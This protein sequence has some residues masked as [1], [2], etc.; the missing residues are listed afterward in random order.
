MIRDELI[1]VFL[2][3][4]SDKVYEGRNR[5]RIVLGTDRKDSHNSG[6]GDGG[7]GDR[8][9]GTIDIVAGYVDSNPDYLNDKSRIYI[10]A[11]TNPDE[12]FGVNKGTKVEGESALVIKSDNAYVIADKIK[13]VTSDDLSII[14]ENN[15]I[16]VEG[17]SEIKLKIGNNQI[18]IN[19]SNIQIGG[20]GSP[21]RI[22]TEDDIC[23]GTTSDG[24]SVACSFKGPVPVGTP[25]I[26]N[27][28][29]VTIK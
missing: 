18:I 14:M 8:D 23:V 11:K 29:K 20:M 4:L 10:S 19:K 27:N 15:K 24:N 1:P 5:T 26:I 2:R 17:N 21:K 6:W 28:Q 22:I 25:P 3:R 16:E 12:Y 9:S 7:E 13:F